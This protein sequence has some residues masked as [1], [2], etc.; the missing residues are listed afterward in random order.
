MSEYNHTA[1]P[2]GNPAEAADVESRFGELDAAIGDLDTLTT[3]NKS[4]LVAAI[5]EL[6]Y[7]MDHLSSGE[8]FIPNTRFGVGLLLR[9]HR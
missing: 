4:S 2:Y 3:A 1:F 8:G 5:N 9:N 6:V 7:R